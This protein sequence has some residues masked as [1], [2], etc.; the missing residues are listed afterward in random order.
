MS[1]ST[2]QCLLSVGKLIWNNVQM[3][4]LRLSLSFVEI[5]TL[6]MQ[7]VDDLLALLVSGEVT[8]L[9][10]LEHYPGG[11]YVTSLPLGSRPAEWGVGLG[12][13][14]L[15]NSLAGY[16]MCFSSNPQAP[17]SV[18]FVAKVCGWVLK[19]VIVCAIFCHNRCFVHLLSIGCQSL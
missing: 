16:T 17:K 2:P 7:W 1:S 12:H 11:F 6:Y 14:C 3:S 8:L 10:W 4:T 18:I 13:Q 5:V 19:S 9:T 15:F